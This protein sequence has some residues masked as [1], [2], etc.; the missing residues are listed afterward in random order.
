MVELSLLINS[1]NRRYSRGEISLLIPSSTEPGHFLAASI[2]NPSRRICAI[3]SG[4]DGSNH[5]QVRIGNLVEQFIAECLR[6]ST[7]AANMD[8]L[9]LEL[10]KSASG[11]ALVRKH[12]EA[13]SSPVL[14]NV[15]PCG[16]A[17][18]SSCVPDDWLSGFH[19][20]ISRE[21]WGTPRS[22][23]SAT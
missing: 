13:R 6:C 11:R 4:R 2:K 8:G 19:K 20:A 3:V 21:R 16:S 7:W 12:R 18:A 14:A 17:S 1:G 22:M 9:C 10:Q 5:V 23:P 15:K